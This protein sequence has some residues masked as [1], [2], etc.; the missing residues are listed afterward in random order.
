MQSPHERRGGVERPP[1]SRSQWNTAAIL[2]SITSSIL[3]KYRKSITSG[4]AN[5]VGDVM[6]SARAWGGGG[7]E[8][9]GEHIWRGEKGEDEGRGGRE[10]T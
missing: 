1:R 3:H 9:E 4:E 8:G 6:E 7:R 5:K 10:S 2:L